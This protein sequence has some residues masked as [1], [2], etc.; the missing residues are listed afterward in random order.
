[1]EQLW[2]TGSWHDRPLS[3]ELFFAS[4]SG[5]L[6][7]FIQAKWIPAFA[8][9]TRQKFICLGGLATLSNVGKFCRHT[10]IFVYST[11]TDLARFLGLST[12][13]PFC[14]AA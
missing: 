12:S 8:G 14:N 13:V 4:A 7:L 2:A 11:V 10:G 1:M 9:M 3:L 5:A 6:Y